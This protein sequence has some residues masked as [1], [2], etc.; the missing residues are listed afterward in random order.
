M[1]STVTCIRQTGIALLDALMQEMDA[2]LNLQGPLQH[3][4]SGL[5]QY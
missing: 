5:V 2:V 1:Q 3:W 4:P